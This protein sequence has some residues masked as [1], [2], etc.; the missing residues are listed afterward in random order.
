MDTLDKLE[1]E[2]RE[3]AMSKKKSDKKRLDSAKERSILEE[4]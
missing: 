1:E 4:I 2:T 3:V